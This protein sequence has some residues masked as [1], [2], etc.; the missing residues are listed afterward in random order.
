MRRQC[1]RARTTSQRKVA[2][3]G[4]FEDSA[5]AAAV[6]RKAAAASMEP[7]GSSEAFMIGLRCDELPL[8]ERSMSRGGRPPA[9]KPPK[10]QG[11]P[12]KARQGKAGSPRAG[13]PT[14]RAP[15]PCG[16]IK[17]PE[18]S[19]R[20]LLQTVKFERQ[21]KRNNRP[22]APDGSCH[23]QLDAKDGLVRR[24]VPPRPARTPSPR[25]PRCRIWSTRFRV[26]ALKPRSRVR[27]I[28]SPLSYKDGAAQN[29]SSP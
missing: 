10:R 2:L 22:D 25:L 23:A 21:S 3:I 11:R 19:R 26:P 17:C 13:K 8:L 16:C 27:A 12:G 7:S 28:A 1:G 24:C 14:Y 29:S 18:V 15:C 9:S 4:A 6:T 5:G 20:K